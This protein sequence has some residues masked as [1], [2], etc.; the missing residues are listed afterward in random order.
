MRGKVKRDK[1]ERNSSIL[2]TQVRERDRQCPAN[3]DIRLRVSVTPFSIP[4]IVRSARRSIGLAS[5]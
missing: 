2:D 4:L 1:E 5:M 3:I